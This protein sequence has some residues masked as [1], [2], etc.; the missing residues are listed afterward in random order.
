MHKIILPQRF[1]THTCA[2]CGFSQQCSPTAWRS[3]QGRSPI[4]IHKGWDIPIPVSTSLPVLSHSPSSPRTGSSS[5]L[6]RLPA[7]QRYCPVP[8][9]FL[10]GREVGAPSGGPVRGP[11]PPLQ[12]GRAHSGPVPAGGVAAPQ[13]ATLGPPAGPVWRSTQCYAGLWG[14]TQCYAGLWALAH[15]A[16]RCLPLCY[17]RCLCWSLPAPGPKADCGSSYQD[18]MGFNC[19]DSWLYLPRDTGRKPD[20]AGLPKAFSWCSD[21]PARAPRTVPLQAP[22]T[23][24]CP[25][26][27]SSITV[28]PREADVFL[29]PFQPQMLRVLL[30]L[31]LPHYSLSYYQ[32]LYYSHVV[33]TFHLHL[34]CS[35][36]FQLRNEP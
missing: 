8:F 5:Q 28:L 10:S 27:A 26:H 29:L 22:V 17:L 33:T 14:S 23:R 6:L 9:P 16:R 4:F 12:P 20:I 24:P 19:W 11:D 34:Y 21:G 36:P 15:G 35:R 1:V 25:S 30:F 18:F 32:H 13:G 7:A 2:D 3:F 31:T